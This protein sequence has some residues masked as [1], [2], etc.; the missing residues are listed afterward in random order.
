[1][2]N[3]IKQNHSRTSAL[4]TVLLTGHNPL[5]YA[6]CLFHPKIKIPTESPCPA[7]SSISLNHFWLS[8][9]C[10]FICLLKLLIKGSRSPKVE[11]QKDDVN[12]LFR[13]CRAPLEKIILVKLDAVHHCEAS[14][15]RQRV[16]FCCLSFEFFFN[17]SKVNFFPFT[18]ATRHGI[19]F[20]GTSLIC[21]GCMSPVSED[22]AKTLQ[23]KWIGVLVPLPGQHVTMNNTFLPH[24]CWGW[25][26]SKLGNNPCLLLLCKHGDQP[27]PIWS[28]QLLQARIWTQNDFLNMMVNKKYS[29][30]ISE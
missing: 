9:T 20:W 23:R 30:N 7:N 18:R 27:Q 17:G 4:A 6:M 3:R 24:M 11:S 25:V 22:S 16:G 14:C 1:M 21:Y 8:T 28:S 12:P 29:E 13:S 15:Q 19:A 2:E 5:F 26:L 10:S